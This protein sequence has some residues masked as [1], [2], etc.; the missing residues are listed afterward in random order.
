M[1]RSH[2]TTDHYAQVAHKLLDKVASGIEVAAE[3]INWALSYLGD[4]DDCAK[5]PDSVRSSYRAVAA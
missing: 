3:Q 4:L 2:N 1:S 5:V